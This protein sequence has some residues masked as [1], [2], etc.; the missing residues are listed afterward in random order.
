MEE[1]A[2]QGA[3]MRPEVRKTIIDRAAKIKS[4]SDQLTALM[5][6]EKGLTEDEVSRAFDLADEI[7]AESEEII[8]SLFDLRNNPEA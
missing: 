5:Q 7:Q 4:I 1:Q 2:K 3:D 6:S 8:G